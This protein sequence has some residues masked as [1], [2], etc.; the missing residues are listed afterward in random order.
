MK[1]KPILQDIDMLSLA[2]LCKLC[3]M[4]PCA[5]VLRKQLCRQWSKLV[6]AVLD[7]PGMYAVEDQLKSNGVI[8]N[9][10]AWRACM[11]FILSM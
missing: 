4:C 1:R 2:N 8:S 5:S 9:L 3:T 7:L 6:P 11:C 10:P